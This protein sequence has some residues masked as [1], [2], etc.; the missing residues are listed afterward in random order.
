MRKTVRNRHVNKRMK[1]YICVSI[2]FFFWVCPF[3]V[4]D[5]PEAR[6]I[7]KDLCPI[8]FFVQLKKPV[9]NGELNEH[10]SRPAVMQN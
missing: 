1:V 6:I 9:R 10:I 4:A 5:I 7:F 3:F 8:I 2:K